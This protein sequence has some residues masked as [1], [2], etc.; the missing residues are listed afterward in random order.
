MIKKSEKYW[1]VDTYVINYLNREQIVGRFYENRLQKT[2]QKEF[3]IEKAIKRK[4]DKP[5]VK[6]EGYDNLFNSWINK[7]DM[8]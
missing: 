5:Y 6:W 1:A 7:K 8:L 2:N 4:C 3:R